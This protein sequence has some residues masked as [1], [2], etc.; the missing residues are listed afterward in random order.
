MNTSPTLQTR[1]TVYSALLMLNRPTD[2]IVFALIHHRSGETLYEVSKIETLLM[3]VTYTL[4]RQIIIADNALSRVITEVLQ[5]SAGTSQSLNF[6]ICVLAM[7]LA[8]SLSTVRFQSCTLGDRALE[9]RS[10][11]VL[12]T[13]LEGGTRPVLLSFHLHGFHTLTLFSY[14]FYRLCWTHTSPFGV[15]GDARL[16]E[17]KNEA[18]RRMSVNN[19]LNSLI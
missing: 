15:R 5:L 2:T 12:L 3:I 17:S 10:C 19:M 13:L 9:R 16:L 18:I 6:S 11:P 1:Q 7:N 4:C 8:P 14:S